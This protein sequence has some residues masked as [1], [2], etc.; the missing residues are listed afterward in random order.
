MDFHAYSMY[1][2]LPSVSIGNPRTRHAV[3][4]GTN[5]HDLPNTNLR[6]AVRAT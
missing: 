3:V 1:S 5:N 6:S 2:Q 4:I